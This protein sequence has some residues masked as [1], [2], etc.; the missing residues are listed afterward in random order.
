MTG[1][2]MWSL[3][4]GFLTNTLEIYL[5]LSFHFPKLNHRKQT[6]SSSSVQIMC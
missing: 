5:A 3:T 4:V 1:L 2:L 6:K